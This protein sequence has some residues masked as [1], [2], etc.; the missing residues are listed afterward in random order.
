MNDV[1]ALIYI[2]PQGMF[3]SAG[4]MFA[5]LT[6]GQRASAQ[7]C[8]GAGSA[9]QQIYVEMINFAIASMEGDPEDKEAIRIAARK[10][11][12]ELLDVGDEEVSDMRKAN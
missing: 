6:V 8:A 2:I 9:G 12:R 11:I 7:D 1:S 10:L 4:A 5:G 3:I